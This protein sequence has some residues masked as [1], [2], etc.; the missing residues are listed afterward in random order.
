MSFELINTSAEKGLKPGSRGFCTVAMTQGMPAHCAQVCESFSNYTHIFDLN[1]GKYGKN[2]VAWSHYRVK[3]GGKFYSMISRV[4]AHPRD[5]TGRTN[6]IAHHLLLAQPEETQRYAEGPE[7]LMDH[8]FFLPIWEGA[9]AYLPEKNLPI[10]S[11][12]YRGYQAVHWQELGLSGADA[13]KLAQQWMSGNLPTFVILYDEACMEVPLGIIQDLLSLLPPVRRWE[14]GF[15][16]YYSN[17]PLAS[18]NHIRACFSGT[19]AALRAARIPGAVVLDLCKGEIRGL[20]SLP[21]A[22]GGLEAAAEKGTPPDWVK[23]EQKEETPRQRLSP[24]PV[25][26][27]RPGQRATLRRGEG[28]HAQPPPPPGIRPVPRAPYPVK[29]NHQNSLPP[30]VLAAFGFVISLLFLFMIGQI[31]ERRHV[32]KE[33]PTK[34]VTY[35][36][37]GGAEQP[38][39]EPNG[40]QDDPNG[41]D[42]YDLPEETAASP[43]TEQHPPTPTPAQTQT[44]QPRPTP[45]PD[46][47]PESANEPEEEEM[48]VVFQQ[49]PERLPLHDGDLV[50][51]VFRVILQDGSVQDIERRG[52][53]L[54]F[55]NDNIGRFGETFLGK[56]EIT[57]LV[58]FSGNTYTIFEHR[59][60]GSDPIINTE[61][62]NRGSSVVNASPELLEILKAIPKSIV[63][64]AEITSNGHIQIQESRMRITDAGMEIP[65]VRERL[66]YLINQE[67]ESRNITIQKYTNAVRERIDR[68]N[69]FNQSR[70]TQESEDV[71]TH[72]VAQSLAVEF[73]ELLKIPSFQSVF[74]RQWVDHSASRTST[75][76]TEMQR[77]GVAD[78]F[79]AIPQLANPREGD[80]PGQIRDRVVNLFTEALRKNANFRR[81]FEEML[82]ELQ[83][84]HNAE[85]RRQLENNSRQPPAVRIDF[86]SNETEEIW[87]R[88]RVTAP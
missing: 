8:P 1:S 56:Q 68:I 24:P 31:R 75:F 58:L 65:D 20:E 42:G 40:N 14:I 87:F 67:R 76:R 46:P 57:H 88:F 16:T 64:H 79:N 37:D 4:S 86:R 50:V 81:S 25:T 83:T 3:A 47:T 36:G 39:S 70:R 43:E 26:T 32:G 13:A 60:G 6:K 34:Y 77:L 44:P 49:M 84:I 10:P 59:H 66:N 29:K 52:N 82:G 35:D 22:G 27:A 69:T 51:T 23:V 21:A 28:T 38:G 9:P 72:R 61:W 18:E 63:V 78:G 48:R 15:S 74:N 85:L 11:Q 5:Y 71:F 33:E 41:E 17:H 7:Q 2:P 12:K 30:V 53:I 62:Q 45:T 54:F 80:M 73:H 19:D 55:R